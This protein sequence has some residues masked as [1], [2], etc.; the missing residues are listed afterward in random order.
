M[1]IQLNDIDKSYVDP[2]IITF[3]SHSQLA[4]DSIFV[5]QWITL[6]L[7]KNK[8][9]DLCYD[10][11]GWLDDIKICRSDFYRMMED[12]NRIF[13]INNNIETE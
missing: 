9:V 12:V 11:D 1:L 3:I 8:K 5:T 13:K 4:Q 2:K 7:G 10:S 6:Y